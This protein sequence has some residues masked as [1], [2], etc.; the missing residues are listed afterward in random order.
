[1]EGSSLAGIITAIAAVI[2]AVGGVL[3]AVG[4]LIPNLRETRHLRRE[5]KAVHEIVNQQRT[6]MMRYQRAL[7]GALKKAGVDVPEDQSKDVDPVLSE[8]NNPA[9]RAE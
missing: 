5:T 7:V 6:D 1:M 3:L 8:V 2:T 4:V 9:L